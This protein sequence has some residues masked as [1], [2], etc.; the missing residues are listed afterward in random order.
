VDSMNCGGQGTG[1]RGP[2]TTTARAVA[3]CNL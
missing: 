2:P 1:Y 3:G